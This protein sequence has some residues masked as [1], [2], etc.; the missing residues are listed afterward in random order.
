MPRSW[1]ILSS[2]FT[3]IS[4]TDTEKESTFYTQSLLYIGIIVREK[5]LH[6]ISNLTELKNWDFPRDVW[7][8]CRTGPEDAK[9]SKMHFKTKHQTALSSFGFCGAWF[10]KIYRWLHFWIFAVIRHL[11]MSEN[12]VGKRVDTILACCLRFFHGT[13]I[14]Q[15]TLLYR[16]Y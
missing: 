10:D 7:R 14:A 2:Q 13:N 15:E 6:L 5:I 8:K 12:E 4:V 3:V 1:P 9:S 11:R 16:F